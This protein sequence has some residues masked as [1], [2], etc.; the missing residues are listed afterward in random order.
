[1]L[2]FLKDCKLISAP[3][4]SCFN[5]SHTCL[6][7]FSAAVA[8]VSIATVSVA[9]TVSVSVAVSSAL[10]SV[11]S[12]SSCIST[13]FC[14]F[15]TGRENVASSAGAEGASEGVSGF[16]LTGISVSP[17]LFN[18]T[19]FGLVIEVFIPLFIENVNLYEPKP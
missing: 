8:A 7:T 10:T 6:I 2:Y 11:S 15:L 3:Y 17:E 14:C 18:Q 13:A 16:S 12:V 5:L 4:V 19:T 9:V 1:M